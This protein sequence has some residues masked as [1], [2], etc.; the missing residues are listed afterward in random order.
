VIL[1]TTSFGGRKEMNNYLDGKHIGTT[2]GKCFFI[3]EVAPGPHTLIGDSENKYV[4]K[5]EFEA[6]RVYFIQQT[7]RMGVWSARTT[8]EPLTLAEAKKEL[9]E[10]DMQFLVNDP[11]SEG[12]KLSDSDLKEALADYAKDLQKNPSD[13]KEILAYKGETSVD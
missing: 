12:D 9:K 6:G 5:L 13:Y 4:V 1:R 10:R 2:L 11:K 8:Y 3:R 7:V